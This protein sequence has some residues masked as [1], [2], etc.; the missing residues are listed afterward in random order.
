MKLSR[1]KRLVDL[2]VASTAVIVGGPVIVLTAA[3]VYLDVGS[4]VLFK[5][6]R[7]GLG[8]SRFDVVKFRTMRDAIGPDGKA[9]PDHAR[10]TRVGRFLRSTSLDELPQLLNVLK[11]DMSI[12]GPRPFIADY[13]SKYSARQMRRHEMRPGIT[14]LAQVRG[15]NSLTWEQRIELDIWYVENWSLALDARILVETVV[16]LVRRTGIDASETTTMTRFDEA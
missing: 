16:E 6:A 8:G 9:L 12:I 7:G 4:P 3:A 1:L 14:G 5:Q 13:L 11:G 2:A 10:I 15:R